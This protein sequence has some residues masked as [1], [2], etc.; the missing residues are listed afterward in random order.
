MSTELLT[1]N[2]NVLSLSGLRNALTGEFLNT[3]VVAA[4]LTDLNG[5]DVP[6]IQ[7]PITL[8]YVAGSDGVYQALLDGLELVNKRQYKLTLVAQGDGLTL[9]TEQFITA[10]IRR[11]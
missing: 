11:E 6:G 8:P 10:T 7:M 2:S 3:A 1:D 5:V 4:T 9:S